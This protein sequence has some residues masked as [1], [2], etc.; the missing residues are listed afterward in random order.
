MY[1]LN[2]FFDAFNLIEH[3][4]INYKAVYFFCKCFFV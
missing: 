3:S 1:K 4:E 2:I